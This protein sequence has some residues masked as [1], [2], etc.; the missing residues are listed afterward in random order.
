MH[1]DDYDFDDKNCCNECSSS[2]CDQGDYDVCCCPGPRGPRGFRGPAGEAGATGA[3]G[4]TGN[5]GLTGATGA[6]GLSETITIRSTTTADP[7]TP[8][9]VHD[10]G[11][12]NHVLDFVIPRG[13]TGITGAT[14][15]TGPGGGATGPTG[16]TGAT[17]NTGATGPIGATGPTGANGNTG[18]TGAIA[19]K[20][21]KK[22]PEKEWADKAMNRFNG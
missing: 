5:T 16:A 7:G 14:G 21:L 9:Q 18:P 19:K 8:A 2:S 10:S 12:P 20:M 4:A 22:V 15:P 1:Y 11:G 3:T 17:G 6:T 13:D